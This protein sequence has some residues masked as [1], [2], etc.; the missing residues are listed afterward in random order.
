MLLSFLKDSRCSIYAVASSFHLRLVELLVT[1]SLVHKALPGVTPKLIF[2]K[3]VIA[4]TAVAYLDWVL[5]QSKDLPVVS[6]AEHETSGPL[7][8]EN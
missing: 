7:V 5:T 8:L 2:E 3:S 6:A 1:S 4:L